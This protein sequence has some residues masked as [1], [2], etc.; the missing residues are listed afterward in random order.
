MPE[1]AYEVLTALQVLRAHP[2]LA[3]IAGGF[4]HHASERQTAEVAGTSRT[5][6]PAVYE[7][8]LQSAVGCGN[9]GSG[10]RQSSTW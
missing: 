8:V 7:T 5:A 4:L 2:N 1:Y 3:E 9:C 10:G 6:L